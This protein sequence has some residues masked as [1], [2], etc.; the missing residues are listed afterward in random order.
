MT[1]REPSTPRIEWIAGGVGALIL[2]AMLAVLVMTGLSG[3]QPPSVTARI[4]GVQTTANGHV[5]EF[6]VRNDGEVTAADVEIVAEL[7]SGAYVEE[8][9]ARFDYLPPRSERRGGFFFESD[10]RQ[11][12]LS[13]RAEGYN[14]P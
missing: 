5:V 13:L 8:R 1:E 10:P 11:G 4:E 6:S 12:E 3:D 14:K 2:A 7:R 9:R